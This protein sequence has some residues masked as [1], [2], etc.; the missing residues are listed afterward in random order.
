[1]RMRVQPKILRY[2]L[3]RD[4]FFSGP[5]EIDAAGAVDCLESPSIAAVP[6]IGAIHRGAAVSRDYVRSIVD[7]SDGRAATEYALLGPVELRTALERAPRYRTRIASAAY[8]HGIDRGLALRVLMQQAVGDDRPENNTPEHPLR[9][10]GDYL[11]SFKAG[12]GQRKLAVQVGSEWLREGGDVDVGVRVLMHAV[13]PEVCDTST[14]PGLGNTIRIGRGV[15]PLS[16]FDDLS[17]LWDEILDVVGALQESHPAPVLEGLTP[18]LNPEMLVFGRGPGQETAE[19]MRNVAARV[20]ERLSRVLQ[21]RPGGLSRLRDYAEGLELPI[22][23]DIPEEFAALF[24]RRWRGRE[25]DGELEDWE[26]ACGRNGQSAG[27]ASKGK[28]RRLHRPRS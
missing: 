27:G 4:V 26:P 22:E 25:G 3:V 10:L 5:G 8:R 28:N 2:A 21:D 1:M 19:A 15:V 12:I 14:L 16:W 20:I 6:I 17:R 24:P 9:S 13:H 11:G 18:W 7:W 23:F